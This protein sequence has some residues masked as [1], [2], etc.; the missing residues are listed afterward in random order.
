MSS[1]DSGGVPAQT[2][3]TSC[4]FITLMLYFSCEL[5]PQWSIWFPSGPVRGEHSIQMSGEAALQQFSC[6]SS[7]RLK[8][9]KNNPKQQDLSVLL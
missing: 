5:W 8:K 6:A 7:P 3:K 1:R 2:V 4:V 9:K